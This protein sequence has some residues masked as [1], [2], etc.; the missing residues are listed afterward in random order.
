MT[1][2][3]RST[4]APPPP[5]MVFIGRFQPLHRAHLAV[6]RHALTLAP[7][8][9]VVI[10]STGGPRSHRNP[11]TY[12]ERR[13]LLEACL[14]EAE[15]RR[16]T[17]VAIP[18]HTYNDT[19]WIEAVQRGVGG[20]ARAL[21]GDAARIALIGHG[22]DRGTRY[23]LSLFPE[24]DAVRAPGSDPVSATPL[25]ETYFAEGAGAWLDV[26]TELPEPVRDAL[27]LFARST[28]Y[29]ELRD[30][31]AFVRDYRRQWAAAPYPPTFVTVDAVVV[32]SGHVLLVRRKGR[33]GRGL[34]ALPGG[35]LDRDERVIDGVLR[36][37]REETALDVPPGVLRGSIV[38]TRVFDDPHRSARGRTI[39]HAALIH[40]RPSPDLPAVRAQESEV[41]AVRWVPL[42]DLRDDRMFEDHGQIIRALVGLLV[43]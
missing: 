2:S 8:L 26:Q 37:L 21:D 36:E 17:T 32:Q 35:F 4:P 7:H 15:R 14:T 41:E 6:V 9:C 40:L 10:G 24:W 5:L 16:V 20:V 33:P 39:T 28:A 25:R 38:E 13:H 31:Y 19:A 42:A 27:R 1:R 34:W 11:F 23:Y 18:D 43:R 30:E 29:A 22:K 3:P 12:D